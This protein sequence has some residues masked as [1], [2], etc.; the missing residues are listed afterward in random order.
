MRK[1]LYRLLDRPEINFGNRYSP[2]L[3]CKS[4]VLERQ[5]RQI[6]R[7]DRP[8]RLILLMSGVVGDQ[9]PAGRQRHEP[10]VGVV[11]STRELGELLQ[12]VVHQPVQRGLGTAILRA[13]PSAHEVMLPP[14]HQQRPADEAIQ[15]LAGPFGIRRLGAVQRRRAAVAVDGQHAA[16][17]LKQEGRFVAAALTEKRP[18]PPDQPVLAL[19]HHRLDAA[20]LPLRP[21]VEVRLPTPAKVGPAVMGGSTPDVVPIRALQHD[22]PAPRRPILGH[23]RVAQVLVHVPLLTRQLSLPTPPG[24]GVDKQAVLENKEM[25]IPRVPLRHREPMHL[26]PR[27]PLILAPQNNRRGRRIHIM[28]RRTTAK[29]QIQVLLEGRNG[30]LQR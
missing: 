5:L 13:M 28:P 22:R 17:L 9:R 27:R 20:A 26:L 18:L 25:R 1:L 3:R 8:P 30:R 29:G 10:R 14:L 15:R 4:A 6:D 11:A 19:Q 21:G 7:G 2:T 12:L 16:I 24:A 23:H